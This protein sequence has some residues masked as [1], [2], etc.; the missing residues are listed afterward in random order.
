[1]K[2]E[3]KKFEPEDLYEI[4]VRPEDIIMPRG[5]VLNTHKD[6]SGIAYSVRVN[7]K[8]IAILGGYLVWEGCCTLWAV[9][10]DGAKGHARKLRKSINILIAHAAKHLKIRRFNAMIRDD[11]EINK[12]W[13][14][15][16]GFIPESSMYKA[17]PDGSHM[18]TFVLWMEDP[19]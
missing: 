13:A 10:N 18:I 7:G 17:A 15:H 9:V 14:M 4:E 2:Y 16:L 1:M 12:K 11:S 3:V 8:L 5:Q 6:L 19:G